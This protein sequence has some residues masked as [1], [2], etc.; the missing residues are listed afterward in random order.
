MQPQRIGIIHP[1]QMGSVVAASMQSGGHEIYWASEGRSRQTRERA[2]DLRLI[3]AITIS[4]LGHI[5]SMI[6]SVCPPE[7]A[8]DVADQ[9]LQCSFRGLFVDANAISPERVRRMSGRMGGI[10]FVDACI[11]GPATRNPGQTW[12]YFSGEN[13]PEA[14]GFFGPGPLQATIIY[15][16]IGAASALKMCFAAYS[17]GASAL[18]CA[19]L[20]AAEQLGVRELLEKQWTLA[21]GA[22]ANP[23]PKMV[24]QI[25]PK[26][27]RFAPEMREIAATFESARLPGG[28]HAAAAEIYSRLAEFRD[29]PAPN[30]DEVVRALVGTASA[31]TGSNE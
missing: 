24:T 13:A 2:S 20:A 11:I 12:I 3:D 17:K 31:V 23:V 14:A 1:G 9:V 30:V 15:G 8:D 28:F 29:A 22:A 10:T 18:L 6:V 4:R 5:C 27:W 16:D 19:A 21:G 7:F 25:A 26:A